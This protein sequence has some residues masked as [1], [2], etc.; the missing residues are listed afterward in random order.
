[1]IIGQRSRA[2][3]AALF[4]VG[5][6][7][8]AAFAGRALKT[9]LADADRL[10][11][12]KSYADALKAYELL[13]RDRAVPE[14]RKDEVA[15]RVAVSLGKTQQWDRALAQSVDFVKTHRGSVWEPRGLYWLGR[16][17]IGAPH[18][19]YRI[20]PRVFR[21]NDVP[22][23]P[24]SDAAPER[25]NL[26]VQDWQNAHDAL[27]AARVLFGAYRDKESTLRGRDPVGFRSGAAAEPV[28]GHGSLG[29]KARL[30][31]ARLTGWKVDT[32][33]RYD[34]KWPAPKR[35][36]YLY[37]QIPAISEPLKDGAHQSALALFGKA[38]W[39]RLYH[40]LMS[41]YARRYENGTIIRSSYPY[42]NETP[43]DTLTS[44]VTQ[45][46][47]DTVRDQAQ[48]TIAH[49]HQAN[50]RFVAAVQELRRLIAERPARK[51][52]VDARRDL[53]QITRK[54]LS[55]SANDFR[56]RANSQSYRAGF[57]NVPVVSFAPFA[58]NSSL[59]AS[60]THAGEQQCQP[61]A[62]PVR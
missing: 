17:Y 12:E 49:W 28:A 18:S 22:K 8:L 43:E 7:A 2:R 40:N 55:I 57:R 32:S 35:V 50:S 4:I 61:A 56:P 42:E 33:Q 52:T 5:A 13:L 62:E 47:N 10:Y 45:Y 29:P 53:E 14:A 44:L 23:E 60:A 58:S 31:E 15:F 37:A 1:M 25:V 46:P 30:G 6:T 59:P 26:S 41:S 24:G 38:L 11:A 54:K 36:M 34:P 51:W 27:E 20:G 21:G 16:L 19:G 3:W 9:D 48:Y 39:L